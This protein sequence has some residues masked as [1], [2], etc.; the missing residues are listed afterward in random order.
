MYTP[1]QTTRVIS[2]FHPL[3]WKRKKFVLSTFRTILTLTLKLRDI[4]LKPQNLH[5]D[6]ID[7]NSQMQWKIKSR[8]WLSST[9]SSRLSQSLISLI[10]IL[11][12]MN[13]SVSFHAVS[14]ETSGQYQCHASNTEGNVTHITKVK[15]IGKSALMFEYNDLKSVG[16]PK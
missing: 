3:S 4:D 7:L 6:F 11:Q 12:I 13:G 5:F 16:G 14:R 8:I 1:L 10:L 9:L 15:V 2:I